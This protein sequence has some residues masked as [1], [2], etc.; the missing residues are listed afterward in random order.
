[1]IEAGRNRLAEY[2]QTDGIAPSM[3]KE[4]ELEGKEGSGKECG[5]KSSVVQL[6]ANRMD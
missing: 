4:C 1:M 5:A 3:V 2:A 6:I